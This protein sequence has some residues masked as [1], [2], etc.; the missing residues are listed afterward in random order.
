MNARGSK[1]Q[2]IILVKVFKPSYCKKLPEL[3]V[4]SKILIRKFKNIVILVCYSFL[5]KC[6]FIYLA[7]NKINKLKTDCYS[8]GNSVFFIEDRIFDQG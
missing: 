8:Y 1:S 6:Q 2:V 7:K 4:K 5:L 3:P